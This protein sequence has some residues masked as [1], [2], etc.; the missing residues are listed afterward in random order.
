MSFLNDSKSI[1]GQPGSNSPDVICISS[2]VDSDDDLI[3]TNVVS[4][5]SSFHERFGK[6]DWCNENT[7]AC[8]EK[9]DDKSELTDLPHQ[10]TVSILKSDDDF[11]HEEALTKLIPLDKC[12][13]GS[14]SHPETL[15]SE[16]SQENCDVYEYKVEDFFHANMPETLTM[17]SEP[18]EEDLQYQ[19][20]TLVVKSLGLVQ[21][22][23]SVD[24]HRQETHVTLETRDNNAENN[25]QLEEIHETVPSKLPETL[26][27][28]KVSGKIQSTEEH[29]MQCEET[30][31]TLKSQVSGDLQHSQ[32][33]EL[34]G[35]EY[36]KD[37][38]EFAT[39]YEKSMGEIMSKDENAMQDLHCEETL[40]TLKP[41]VNDNL[42]D[43]QPIESIADEHNKGS[44]EFAT[45]DKK[46]MVEILAKDFVG[47]VQHEETV[48]TKK[49]QLKENL[50]NIEPV[51][52]IEDKLM[53]PDMKLGTSVSSAGLAQSKR[54]QPQNPCKTGVIP[55]G[56][57]VETAAKKSSFV[58]Q[59]V[60]P[61][62]DKNSE[63]KRK[64]ETETK[65]SKPLTIEELFYEVS[66]SFLL[67]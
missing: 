39:K 23:L 25:V 51:K 47:N 46:S 16:I 44:I 5:D 58:S 40:S 14:L 31:S 41:Q 15:E 2:D 9:S 50:E 13:V 65:P 33:V 62:P 6:A 19:E 30:L 26:L 4:R 21:V 8:T 59:V 3:I 12:E 11:W 48:F 7:L 24:S 53:K 66:I 18:E 54:T 37:N 45:K 36:K 20:R 61:V 35:D 17:N 34:I 60:R 67:S 22:E 57:R 32:P 28:E 29:V 27:Y 55:S 43:M 56:R 64:K 38:I 52:S 49:S 10:E 42:Q 1:G 63:V